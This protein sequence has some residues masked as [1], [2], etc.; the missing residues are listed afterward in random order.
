[1]KKE[2]LTTDTTE[3]QRIVRDYCKQ[4]YANKMENLEKMD[5]FF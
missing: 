2:K 4:I 5:I 1:M 3:I